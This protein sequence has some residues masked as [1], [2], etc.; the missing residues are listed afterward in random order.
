MTILWFEQRFKLHVI[1]REEES[2]YWMYEFS[3][4]HIYQL[5]M[6]TIPVNEDIIPVYMCYYKCRN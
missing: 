3:N 1:Y 2:L 6:C 5:I 4:I